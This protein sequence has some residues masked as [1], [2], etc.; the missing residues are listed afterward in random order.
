M[1][2]KHSQALYLTCALVVAAILGMIGWRHYSAMTNAP[3]KANLRLTF[4]RVMTHLPVVWVAAPRER[5]SPVLF[6]LRRE[7]KSSESLDR[8]RPR[9]IDALIADGWH[10][11]VRPGNSSE[12]QAGSLCYDGTVVTFRVEPDPPGTVGSVTMFWWSGEQHQ[13]PKICQRTTSK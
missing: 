9:L 4:N 13:L 7:F 10:P 6:S 12:L 3:D 11:Y 2:I 8:A 1:V 5:A